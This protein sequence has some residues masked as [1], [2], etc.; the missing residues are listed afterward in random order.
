M[1]FVIEDGHYVL[2]CINVHSEGMDPDRGAVW[3]PDMNEPAKPL[4]KNGPSTMRVMDGWRGLVMAHPPTRASSSSSSS[5]KIRPPGAAPG[6][7]AMT[8]DEFLGHN[9]PVPMRFDASTGTP[10]TVYVCTVCGYVEMYYAPT[11]EPER[12]QG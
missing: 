11:I 10:V 1:P 2:R 12:W 7:R 3:L 6:S 4:P 5:E 9:R 8:M